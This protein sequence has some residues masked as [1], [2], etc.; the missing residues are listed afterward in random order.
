ML[1]RGSEFWAAAGSIPL[2]IVSVGLLILFL[3][4]NLRLDGEP[5]GEGN[6]GMASET[7]KRTSIGLYAY[8]AVSLGFIG[9][10]ACTIGLSSVTM[11]R[12]PLPSRRRP[13]MPRVCDHA[14]L[15]VVDG[16]QQLEGLR[17]PYRHEDPDFQNA[18]R[19]ALLLR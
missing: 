10:A 8:N 18:L 9:S 3:L 4:L 2:S 11:P 5:I 17:L 14:P 13:K 7:D 15:V 1:Y 12:A 6:N 19:E 16:R